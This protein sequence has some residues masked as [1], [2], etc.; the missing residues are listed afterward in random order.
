MSIFNKLHMNLDNQ[1]A[2]EMCNVEGSALRGLF[3]SL[4]HMLET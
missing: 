4:I 2:S 3:A 1:P